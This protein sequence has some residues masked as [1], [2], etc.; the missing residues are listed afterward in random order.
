MVQYKGGSPPTM[1]PVFDSSFGGCWP[2]AEFCKPLAVPNGGTDAMLTTAGAGDTT[3]EAEGSGLSAGG[4]GT[5]PST[6]VGVGG[7]DT[8][9]AAEAEFSGPGLSTSGAGTGF[10]TAANVGGPDGASA[11]AGFDISAGSG[12]A[13]L[14]PAPEVT[15]GGSL[16][17]STGAWAAIVGS[18]VA[19]GGGSAGLGSRPPAVESCGDCALVATGASACSLGR[20]AVGGSRAAIGA[21][22]GGGAVPV[23]EVFVPAGAT[24]GD[25]VMMT[26]RSELG[27][28][29]SV[30]LSAV[31]F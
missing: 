28:G 19:V 21:T 18:R 17:V 14:R 13:T 6:G 24:A 10:S 2:L 22:A 1:A 29:A 8:A 11:G 30:T 3:S 15:A 7:P 12:V 5:G 27:P 31:L 16:G 20:P 9:P 26:G 4:S 25:T 23:A